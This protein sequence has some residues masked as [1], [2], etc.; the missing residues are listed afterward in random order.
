[1]YLEENP[2]LECYNF[3]ENFERAGYV[4]EVNWEPDDRVTTFL[5]Q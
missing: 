3:F 2:I 5:Y 1:M 4:C